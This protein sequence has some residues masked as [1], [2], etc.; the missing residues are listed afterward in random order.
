ME[1]QTE[2]REPGAPAENRVEFPGKLRFLFNPSRYKVM[3]GGRGGG[4]SWGVARALILMTASRKLRVLCAREYQKSIA[5]SVHKLLCEQIDAMGLESEFEITKATIKARR[6]GS[7]FIFNGIKTDP[8]QI[9]STEGIDVAWVEEAEKVS[10]DSWKVLIPTIRK[11]GSEIWVTFNP[12]AETDPTYKRFIV[13]APDNAKVV[14]INW[15]DNPWFPDALVQEMEYLQR[16]DPDACAHVY[17]GKPRKHGAAQILRG[18]CSVQTF[19]PGV[20]WKGPYQGADWGF[21]QSPTTL[22]RCW[23]HDRCLWIEH[24]V[25]RVGLEI[26]ETPARFDEI[27]S[28]RKYVTRA[29]CARPETISYMRAHGYPNVVAVEKWGGSVEDGI[30]FLRQF[31]LIVI[32]PRCVHTIDESRLWSY[33]QDKLTGDTLPE[34]IDAHNHCWDAIRYALGPLIRVRNPG[35]FF[36]GTGVSWA[37]GA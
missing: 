37:E 32:H 10:E 33:K 5:D 8:A 28:A 23:V 14:E 25:W 9:K 13:D 34:L 6:T 15:S 29:D 36:V 27:P 1:C 17:G 21:A 4:K 3:H 7:E 11:H 24:E 30:A 19:E 22:I 18:K 12:D 20:G 35:M 2:I 31:E 26:N 16:V